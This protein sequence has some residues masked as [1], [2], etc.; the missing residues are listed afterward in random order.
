M[1]PK[2]ML[3]DGG[4]MEKLSILA[5]AATVCLAV[6]PQADAA[7][8]NATV[9]GTYG[10]TVSGTLF[11]PQGPAPVA[12]AGSITFDLNGNVSGSQNRSVGGTFLHETFQGTYRIGGECALQFTVNVYD[13]SGTLLRTSVVDGVVV[14]N[15][16]QI[17][18]M[19]ESTTLPNGAM[20]QS[21]LTAGSSSSS[22]ARAI[23]ALPVFFRMW[24]KV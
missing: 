3:S 10:Y 17:R 1:N 2:K 5:V 7:C 13:D 21:A 6:L 8:S 12:A 19:F 9:N 15:G 24:R 20:L 23:N 11:V 18:A 4:T 16:K 14:D 22:R